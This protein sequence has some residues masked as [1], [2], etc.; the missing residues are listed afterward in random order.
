MLEALKKQVC[1]M[2]RSLPG[3][4]LVTMTSGNVSGF[5]RKTRCMVI[6][7]SGVAFDKLKPTDMVVVS[8][9]GDVVGGKHAPSVDSLS[10]LL[11][12]LKRPDL[13]GIVH[14]HSNYATSFALLGKPLPVYLTSHADEFG[15]TVPVTRF[16][17]SDP[18]DTGRA[19]WETLKNSQMPA[20]LVRQHGVFTFGKD[21]VAAVKAA[22]MIE[23][24]AK[25]CHL[26]LLLGNPKP[27]PAREAQKYYYRYHH[28]YGQAAKRKNIFYKIK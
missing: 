10:H 27:L 11:I 4:G 6:K 28:V 15:E 3:H 18:D 22:V 12:Y 20:V 19:I 21:P 17:S 9:K 14:T 7:P 5:D 8:S 1:A 23:D 2:N 16:A 26:A 13:G 24:I 25:T